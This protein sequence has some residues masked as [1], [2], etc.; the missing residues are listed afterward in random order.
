MVEIKQV[1]KGDHAPVNGNPMA[2]A[3]FFL[4]SVLEEKVAQQNSFG[5]MASATACA[6]V[7]ASL[8]PYHPS[9][10]PALTAPVEMFVF[11]PSYVP[12]AT[13]YFALGNILYRQSRSYDTAA[14]YY[15]R[16][17]DSLPPR[18]DL[19]SRRIVVDQLALAYGIS[20]Q[21]KRSR[22]INAEAIKSDPDYPLYYY[23]LAC[24]DAEQGDA[25]NA[26]IHLQQAFDRR[27]NTIPGEPMPDPAK[28]DSILK[29]KGDQSFWTFVTALPKN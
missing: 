24:A 3:S 22:D 20:G 15:Q 10:E 8:T 9:E 29:L 12:S 27:A 6:E 4:A 23:N 19:N 28:D 14:I 5:V 7:H 17:L 26:R 25:K 21:L 2:T 13:D 1:K 18:T 11:D 16:T